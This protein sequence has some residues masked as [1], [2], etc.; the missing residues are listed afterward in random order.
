[1]IVLAGVAMAIW[2]FDQFYLT[3]QGRKIKNLKN[4]IKIADQKINEL[5]L[6]G[7]GIETIEREIERQEKELKRLSDRTL[8]GEEFRAFLK[9]LAKES[10][11]GQM[12]VISV[13]PQE[14]KVSISEDKR[15][16][17]QKYR[18]VNIQMVLHST[19]FKL[20]TYLKGIE[21]L[22]FLIHVENLQIEKGEETQPLLK[23][24][25]KLTIYIPGEIEGV[26][27]SEGLTK[28]S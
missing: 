24:T 23:V 26:K 10:D 11:P 3:P 13:V 14:E 17:P 15:E 7:K 12:K 16:A 21:E 19:Y 5:L 1:M 25:I 6:I 28:N 4:E 22:P 20:G 9:H 8:R 27:G 18:K 2:V